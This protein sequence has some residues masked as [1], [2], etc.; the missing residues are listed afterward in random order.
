MQHG[1]ERPLNE[2]VVRTWVDLW[3]DV[4]T[5]LTHL[6]VQAHRVP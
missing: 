3:V 5:V 2:L 6:Q 4:S 1:S